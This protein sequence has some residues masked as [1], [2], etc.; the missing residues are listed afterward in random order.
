MD[1]G[2]GSIGCVYLLYFCGKVIVIIDDMIID[3]CIVKKF[4][5]WKYFFI[6]CLFY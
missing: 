6:V 5:F 2:I 1:I 4:F 3:K